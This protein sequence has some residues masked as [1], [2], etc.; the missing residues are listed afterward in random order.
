MKKQHIK[1]FINENMLQTA[2]GSLG[3][4]FIGDMISKGKTPKGF[5]DY[6]KPT[7]DYKKDYDNAEMQALLRGSG[8]K[9]ETGNL[10]PPDVSKRMGDLIKTTDDYK[11]YLK[12][13][14]DLANYK[15]RELDYLDAKAAQDLKYKIGGG[16]IGGTAGF[17]TS[18]KKKKKKNE[19]KV[20]R[21]QVHELIER[22]QVNEGYATAARL[23][24]PYAK[25]AAKWIG[26][27]YALEKGYNYFFGSD[28]K[29]KST[30]TQEPEKKEYEYDIRQ[31]NGNTIKTGK[32]QF[33]TNKPSKSSRGSMTI[34]PK[35]EPVDSLKVVKQTPKTNTGKYDFTKKQTDKE[36]LDSLM[37][38][39]KFNRK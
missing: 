39:D 36:M 6:K 30:T 26:I 27:P 32:N 5:E 4:M 10:M 18:K 34:K 23:A 15:E 33:Y 14:K 21:K 38:L 11:K 37:N 8:Y 31:K 20:S 22:V 16:A 9:D 3:G 25:E 2:L 12:Y 24:W 17:L 1:K 29:P 19:S 28:E 13:K 7:V 35:S